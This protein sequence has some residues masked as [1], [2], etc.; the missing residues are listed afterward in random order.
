LSDVVEADY[1]ALAAH[2]RPG[3]WVERSFW[4]GAAMTGFMVLMVAAGASIWTP[5]TGYLSLRQ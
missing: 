2:Q 4:I 5:K 3:T 1:H